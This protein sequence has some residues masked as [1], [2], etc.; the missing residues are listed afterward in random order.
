MKILTLSTKFKIVIIPMAF[1]LIAKS[2]VSAQTPISVQTL[3]QVNTDNSEF[4][5]ILNIF[6]GLIGS[7]AL[8]VIVIAGFRYIVSRGE[9]QEIAR[10][11]N[12]IIY[13]IVGL[14]I[15]ILAFSIV[16]FVVG[17]L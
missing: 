5:I 3:P 12:T 15:A 17:N 8:L 13:A 6:F 11:K 10:A 7:I 14:V 16:N 1:V 9:P 4:K 2:Y